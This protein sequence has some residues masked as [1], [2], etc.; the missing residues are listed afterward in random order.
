MITVTS[1][2]PESVR[3]VI[4]SVLQW[5]GWLG[6]LAL[7]IWATTEYDPHHGDFA[8]QWVGLSVIFLVGVSIAATSARARMR[9]SDTITK[10]FTAGFQTAVTNREKADAE[11]VARVEDGREGDHPGEGGGNRSNPAE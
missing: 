2:P 5:F 6:S 4:A 8:P 11:K 7:I 1:L 10:T 9:L 3:R